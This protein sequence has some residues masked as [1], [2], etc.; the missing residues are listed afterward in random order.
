VVASRGPR[1]Y[2]DTERALLDAARPHFAQMW[3]NAR[4]VADLEA[5]LGLFARAV[6]EGLG[7]LVA[8]RPDGSAKAMTER[9]RTLLAAH[10][11]GA[12]R[13]GGWPETL[14]AW[15]V[16]QL[17]TREAEVV[18]LRQPLTIERGDARLELRLVW[19]G[20]DHVV[21][22]EPHGTRP[23]PAQL[24]TLGL[25]RREAEVLHWVA[26]GKTNAEVGVILGISPT[27]VAK[28]LDHV[29]RKL[30]VET[31][32]AAAALVLTASAGRGQDAGA[33]PA[34]PR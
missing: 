31:R 30:G 3:Q 18:P 29:Y 12:R 11:P 32:T 6:D 23:A 24:E 7:S 17:R 28:H 33:A 27:T 15:V 4:A 26:Q 16:R 14:R 8:V 22:V 21:L 1:A 20:S 2:S 19:C 10:F 25:S 5:R 34:P 13:T 9:A